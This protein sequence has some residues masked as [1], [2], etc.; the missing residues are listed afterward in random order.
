MFVKK[1]Y[2]A[3]NSIG[4][5]KLSGQKIIG[6]VVGG[7][8]AGEAVLSTFYVLMHRLVYKW[9]RTAATFSWQMFTE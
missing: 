7:L 4:R 2:R 8:G 5:K 3:I 1:N 6:Q 9:S